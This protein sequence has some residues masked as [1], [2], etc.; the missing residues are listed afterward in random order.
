MDYVLSQM[1]EQVTAARA[2]F[3]P[4]EIVG[5][6]TK[7]FLGNPLSTQSQDKAIR[8][9]MKAL[10]GVIDYEPNELVITAWAGTPLQE[11]E[12]TLAK[13][14]QML[15]FDPP[16]FGLGSTIGGA[17]AAGLSGPL[18]FGYGPLRHY[19]LGTQLLDAQGRVL[20]F[21]GQVM[22]NVAG[23]DVSRLLAGSLGMFG[24][25]V[26]LSLK[27]MPVPLRDQTVLFAVDE[28]EAL[29]RCAGLR[30]K[31]W[32]VKAASWLPSAKESGGKGELA[33]RL[34]GAQSAVKEAREALG[35]DLLEPELAGQWWANFRDQKTHFF[36][37]QPLWRMAVRS[38]TPVL[39]LG[40]T[41][42]D[43]GGEVR[44]I[45]TDREAQELRTRASEAGGHATLFRWDGEQPV[46]P[47]GVFQPLGATTLAVVKRLKDEFDPKSIFNS[48]RLVAG[49]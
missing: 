30:A 48:G 39:S 16:S 4:V 6:G 17:V 41:A 47:N 36:A 19:V 12:A 3:R 49:L 15:A 38:N 26:Q 34:C 33:M 31:S 27:V 43:M 10:S 44:W 37:G 35:G 13:E 5:G 23:Y 29:A 20:T 8:L 42:F 25:I 46:P 22:K 2:N 1:S 24:A 14:N 7:R 28:S 9:E 32:P 21:G 11:I 40:D 45:R 18:S